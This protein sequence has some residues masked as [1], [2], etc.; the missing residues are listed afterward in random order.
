MPHSGGLQLQV[1]PGEHLDVPLLLVNQ[2][3]R[4]AAGGGVA[5]ERAL[6]PAPLPLLWPERS[7][8]TGQRSEAMRLQRGVLHARRVLHAVCR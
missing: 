3:P 6:K 1:V 8:A 7:G 2:T 4:L 5:V